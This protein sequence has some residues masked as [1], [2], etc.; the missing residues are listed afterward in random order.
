MTLLLKNAHVIDKNSPAH[1]QK[2]DLLIEDGLISSLD[3]GDAKETVDLKGKFVSY[4][5]FDLNA[6]FNDPGYEHRENLAT[7]IGVASQGGFT[8]VCLTPQ[9]YPCIETKSDVAYLKKNS[10]VVDIHVGAA[11]SEGMK[12]ENL[13]EMLDLFD[14]GASLFSEGDLPIWNAELLLKALQYTQGINAPVVQ[15][16]QDKHL[17]SDTY[18]HEGK[19]STNLGLRGEPSLSEELMIRRDLDILRYAGGSIHFSRVSSR[20]GVSLIREAKKEGL[21]ITCDVGIHHLLFDDAFIADFDTNFKVIPH[22]RSD[23]DKKA[24]IEGLLDG[25]VDAICSNHRPLDQ[26]SKQ[27]EFDLAEPGTISLQTFYPCLLSL[28]SQVPIENLV[29]V[30]VNGA[31]R[32]LNMQPRSIS[33]NTEAKLTVLDPNERWIFNGDTNLSKSANSPFFGKTLLGRVI[34]TV[35]RTY[36][37][38]N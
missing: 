14:A 16:P 22:Y 5:W 27:L 36:V 30:M 24:L 10:D 19:S 8:D 21:Q 6:H 4:G 9:T 17:S 34:G 13:N 15:N 37:N 20:G 31:R 29:E 7:G 18:M 23:D 1:A 26:E 32:V 3:G 2:V 11:L 35:N 25:T 12:G 33:P 38:L 28:Q